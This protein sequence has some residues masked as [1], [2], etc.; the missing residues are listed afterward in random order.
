M[1]D[2]AYLGG[3]SVYHVELPSGLVVQAFMT[4]AERHVQRPTWDD[5]VYV[6]WID[7]SGVVLQS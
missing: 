3:H 2:I 1:R 4:N 6:A 7:D 5:P